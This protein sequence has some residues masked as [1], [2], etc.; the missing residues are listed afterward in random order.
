M[1]IEYVAPPPLS[2][3]LLLVAIGVEDDAHSTG[4]RCTKASWDGSTLALDEAT[5]FEPGQGPGRLSQTKLALLDAEMAP[6]LPG[7]ARRP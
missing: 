2:C 1:K 6:R 4:V 3:H 5:V 7:W